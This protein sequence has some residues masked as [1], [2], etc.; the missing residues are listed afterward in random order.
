MV[1][2]L[3]VV[4]MCLL[5]LRVMFLYRF[6]WSCVFLFLLKTHSAVSRLFMA[7]FAVSSKRDSRVAVLRRTL[8]HRHVPPLFT[9][10]EDHLSTR[11]RDSR[12]EYI[13]RV[14][15]ERLSGPRSLD[16]QPAPHLFQP[17]RPPLL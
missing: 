13:F 16:G 12:S 1:L 10:E 7:G 5:L 9:V 4:F 3:M 6:L 11:G 17:R 2:L 14:M 8:P 15:E